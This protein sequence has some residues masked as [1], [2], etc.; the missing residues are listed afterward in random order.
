MLLPEREQRRYVVRLKDRSKGYREALPRDPGSSFPCNRAPIG[1]C[2]QRK[3]RANFLAAQGGAAHGKHH[4]PEPRRRHTDP[5]SGAGD[6]QR[7]FDGEGGQADSSPGRRA[8]GEIPRSDEHHPVPA[9]QSLTVTYTGVW[10]HY[11]RLRT[12]LETQAREA[13]KVTV[14]NVLTATYTDGLAPASAGYQSLRD[15]LVQ[16]DM[17]RIEVRATEH[18]GMDRQL[19]LG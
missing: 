3:H 18:R 5:P 15:V 12:V 19:P 10:D 7:S 1:P 4:D 11:K 2:L 9:G 13:S 16:L 14:R 6:R 8:R 17:G